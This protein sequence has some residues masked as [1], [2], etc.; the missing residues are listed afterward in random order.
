MTRGDGRRMCR[1]CLLAVVSAC[2][3]QPPNLAPGTGTLTVGIRTSGPE[4]ANLVFRVL[5]DGNPVP[6]TIRADAGVLS[7]TLPAGEHVVTLG[8]LPARCRIDGDAE[9]RLTIPDGHVAP[10][11]FAVICN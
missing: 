7:T 9:R 1:V 6:R 3:T 8:E 2:A 5:V 11:R 4:V 10:V